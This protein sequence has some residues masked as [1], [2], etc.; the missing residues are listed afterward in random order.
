MNKRVGD[1]IDRGDSHDPCGPCSV[2]GLSWIHL[3]AIREGRGSD[4][5]E[6]GFAGWSHR[7][8][9]CQ[10]PQRWAG[11]SACRRASGCTEGC[12]GVQSPGKERLRP[13]PMTDHE[14]SIGSFVI[15]LGVVNKTVAEN[16]ANGFG[17]KRT[18]PATPNE[19]KTTGEPT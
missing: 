18:F 9:R 3:G 11:L 19:Q 10:A 6:L 12:V 16:E 7:T 1:C 2:R 17:D 8:L 5:D 15:P 14:Q 13:D 4:W